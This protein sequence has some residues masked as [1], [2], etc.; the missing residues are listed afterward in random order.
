MSQNEMFSPSHSSFTQHRVLQY[1][2]GDWHVPRGDDQQVG[3]VQSVGFTQGFTG[4]YDGGA[5]MSGVQQPGG[6]YIGQAAEHLRPMPEQP[7]GMLE[8]KNNPEGSC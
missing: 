2:D 3:A 6:G 1:Q 5:G 8:L 7:V 4:M